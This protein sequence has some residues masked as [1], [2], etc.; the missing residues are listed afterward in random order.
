MHGV[1]RQ[2]AIYRRQYAS[3]HFLL[4]LSE[5]CL[6]ATRVAHELVITR[7]AHLMGI[8]N[9]VCVMPSFLIIFNRFLSIYL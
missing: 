4:L 1:L 3:C 9:C 5:R 8:G 6:N 7:R 2:I